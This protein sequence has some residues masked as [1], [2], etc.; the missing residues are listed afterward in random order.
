MSL[1]MV[2]LSQQSFKQRQGVW[3]TEIDT[4]NWYLGNYVAS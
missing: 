4:Y 3:Q 2:I 1:L